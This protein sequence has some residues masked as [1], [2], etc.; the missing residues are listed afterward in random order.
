[1]AR[2]NCS[3]SLTQLTPG[4]GEGVEHGMLRAGTFAVVVTITVVGRL[5]RTTRRYAPPAFVRT[6]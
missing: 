3:V 5:N 6:L 4:N 1:V 2:K